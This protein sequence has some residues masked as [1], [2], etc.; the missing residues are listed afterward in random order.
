M[1][2]SLFCREH[3][4]SWDDCSNGSCVKMKK[5]KECKNRKGMLGVMYSILRRR[6]FF[7]IFDAFVV[8]GHDGEQGPR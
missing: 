3:Y 4:I 2:F 7:Q 8:Y 1:Q 6:V 5:K